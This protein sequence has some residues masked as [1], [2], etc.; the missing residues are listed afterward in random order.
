MK[1]EGQE[2]NGR[3]AAMNAAT[4]DD[5]DGVIR[6]LRLK[7]QGGDVAAARLFLA[8]T[9]SRPGRCRTRIRSTSTR[10]E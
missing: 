7:A 4:A 3:F 6:A 9:I 2:K 5:V 1:A 10:G 8:D